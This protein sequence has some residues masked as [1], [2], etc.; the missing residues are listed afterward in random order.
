[1]KIIER[2]IAV[3]SLTL[4]LFA[5]QS[6]KEKIDPFDD[7]TYL[8]SAEWELSMTQ[9]NINQLLNVAKTAFPE[10]EQI[11]ADV[12]GG[13][14]VYSITYNTTFMGEDLLVSGLVAIPSKGGSY[15]VLAYQNGTNTLHG[16]APSVEPFYLLYQLLECAASTG[17][18]V[19]IADYIGFGASEQLDHPYLHRESTV[20]TVTDMLF[21]LREFD[22]DVAKDIKIEDEYYLMGYSQGGWATLAL[23]NELETEYAAE[24]D[25]RGA[26]CGA[27]P[28]DLSYFN[29]YVLGLS[30][31]PMPV[32][33]G[34]IANAY[35]EYDL[36]T[37]SLDEM[38]SAT[39]AGLIPGLYNGT[40]TSDEIN[41]QLTQNI[42][43]L[44]TPEY[45]SGFAS[46]PDYLTVREA[47]AE[48][49]VEPWDCNIPLLFLHG[50]ADVYVP[51]VL[52]ENIYDGMIDAG[53]SNLT[54]TY[55][56]LHDLDHS[57][58]IVPA[59]L[60]GLAFFKALRDL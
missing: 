10:V 8:M 50:T 24:F 4:V 9:D 57:E 5:G 42:S 56:T 48:N 28:Y 35:T 43:L 21:A 16:N 47:L 60:A 33:L 39:Y 27:G 25:V 7:N 19:I 3:T 30:T 26:V 45:L 55:Q 15:P 6:C 17:Y 54:C 29:S 14:T 12:A 1:M 49:S 51:P 2:I 36:F 59:G 31:Y 37:T 22:E 52:S 18:V 34:Y 38:F 58:G 32:F 53:T 23:L 11:T 41:S 44:F 13:V 40:K 46:S 20:T